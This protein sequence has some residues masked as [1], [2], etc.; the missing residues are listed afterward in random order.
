MNQ[1]EV[2]KAKLRCDDALYAT[3]ARRGLKS[4]CASSLTGMAHLR[5]CGVR[6]TDHVSTIGARFNFTV[7]E[8]AGVWVAT[9]SSVDGSRVARVKLTEWHWSGAVFCPAC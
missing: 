6:C 8:P 4:G 9:T 5:G 1:E 7:F 3:F 2:N